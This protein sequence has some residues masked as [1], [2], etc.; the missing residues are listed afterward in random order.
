[1]SNNLRLYH[2]VL[3]QL[4]QWLSDERITRMRN[5]A[6]LVTG[7]YLRS[8]VQ[9]PL[10]VRKWPLPGKL[11]SLVNRLR[12]F[13]SNER[14]S[15]QRC[16]QPLVQ[17]L[18]SRF[19]DQTIT[20]IVDCTKVGFNH[21]LMVVAIAYRKRA[22][23][24]A[25][26][27]HRGAKGS[28]AVAEQIALLRRVESMLPPGSD[29]CLL[30]DCGF[31][32]I[33]LLRWLN[34]QGWHFVIRQSGNNM[35]SWS[36]QP[37]VRLTDLALV[38]GDSRVVGWARL[39]RKHDY[40]WVWLVLHWKQGEEEP[41]YLVS[42]T[43]GDR[44]SIH[45]YRKRMWIEEMY[46]DMKGHGFNLEA[47]HLR[48]A[49]RIMRLLLGVCI[50]YVWFIAPGSW[51]VKRGFR[52][53]IDRKDRRDKSYFRLGWDRMERCYRLNQPFVLRFIPYL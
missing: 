27:V 4:C 1:M 41:W 9:L 44:T 52:H 26:S 10:V 11:S 21:Q 48:D 7:L 35:V 22:L 13:L 8:A 18:L 49:D 46:G 30:G 15:V 12:R 17:L 36:G 39:T 14:L 33:P 38:E 5:L 40:G 32:F 53:L 29:V 47:T 43:P 45:L 24:L 31:Q 28:I 25:W 3:R 42:D 50:V 34:A 6:L 19:T 2:T 16:Y 23:P 20:L 37:W 51:L